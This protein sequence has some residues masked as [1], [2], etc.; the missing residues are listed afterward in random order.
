MYTITVDLR[1]CRTA[2]DVQLAF[3]KALLFGGPNGQ[4]Q[5]GDGEGWGVNWDALAD[6]LCALPSGGIWGTSPK[7]ELP[8]KL[9][10][11]YSDSL[12]GRRSRHL[13]TLYEILEGTRYLYDQHGQG[14]TFQFEYST[15]DFSPSL[16]GRL[17]R[18][19]GSR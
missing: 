10:I 1:R 14:F 8:V 3:G 15:R 18:V 9:R 17:K 11:L 12:A 13:W 2:T 5:L 6:C 16:W 4:Q 7:I 19:L